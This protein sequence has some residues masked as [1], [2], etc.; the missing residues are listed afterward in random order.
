MQVMQ[1]SARA[2]LM[3]LLYEDRPWSMVEL[4][5]ETGDAIGT[6]DA[7]AELCGAGLVSHIG[8]EHLIASRAA[9][10]AHRLLEDDEGDGGQE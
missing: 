7:V 1:T 9:S 3:L 5:R 6:V 4:A 10:C 8:P 2:V